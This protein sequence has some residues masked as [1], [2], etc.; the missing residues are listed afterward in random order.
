VKN[1]LLATALGVVLV[2]NGWVLIHVARNRTGMPEAEMELTSRELAYYR[3]APN[4]GG[5]TFRLSWQNVTWLDKESLWFDQ[6]KLAELGFDVSKAAG[7]DGSASYYQRMR[8]REVFVALEYDGEAWQRWIKGVPPSPPLSPER[9]QDASH[10]VAIDVASN[11]RDLRQKHPDRSKV[12][13]LKGLARVRVEREPPA[14][15]G[16][17][18]RLTTSEIHV[19]PELAQSLDRGMAYLG[20]TPAYAATIRVGSLYEPWVTYVRRL[21]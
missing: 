19:P 6:N 9:S 17:I 21:R 10:L 11:G 7:A 12:V 3:N 16:S 2:T 8:E 15:R 4:E 18:T 5:V 13:I 20:G 1:P 14:L